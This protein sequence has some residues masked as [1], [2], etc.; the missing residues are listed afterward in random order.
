[1]TYNI[2]AGLETWRAAGVALHVN[3]PSLAPVGQSRPKP[4]GIGWKGRPLGYIFAAA[5]EVP[6]PPWSVSW[7]VTPRSA[8][9]ITIFLRYDRGPGGGVQLVV[10]AVTAALVVQAAA[11]ARGGPG[12]RQ[13]LS[14]RNTRAGARLPD[15]QG[16]AVLDASCPDSV[17]EREAPDVLA[18]TPPVWKAAT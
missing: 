11:D 6:K 16:H 9:P 5:L 17:A 4:A 13:R 3:M 8:L 7:S 12:I 10:Q 14:R 15:R 2:G 1:M 18:V